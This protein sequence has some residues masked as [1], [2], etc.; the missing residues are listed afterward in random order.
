MR[1]LEINKRLIYYAVRVGEKENDLG[2]R[3]PI[4]STPKPLRI[5]VDFTN[6]TAKIDAFG[7][8]SDCKVKLISDRDLGFNL[9]AIF[10]IDTPVSASHDYVMADQPDKTINGVVYRL[11][12]TGVSY[13]D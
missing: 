11:K 4:Y 6:T 10:W 1:T 5:R 13:A 3:K 9:D 12:E 2:E 8:T 7:K